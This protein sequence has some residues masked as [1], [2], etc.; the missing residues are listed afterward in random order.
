MSAD[1]VPKLGSKGDG[2]WFETT[3]WSVVLAAGSQNSPDAAKALA[4]LC[5][6]YWY[7]LYA[8]ARREGNGHEDAKDLTQGFFDKLL[9]N[10]TA[11]TADPGRGRFRNFLLTSFKNYATDEW[12]KGQRQKRGGGCEVI[13]IDGQTAEEWYRLEPVDSATPEILFDRK[14]A[15]ALLSQTMARLESE[16][17]SRPAAFAAL[18]DFLLGQAEGTSYALV[19][20]RLGTSEGA[21]KMMAM[22][23]RRRFQELL[24][25]GVAHTL[26]D[27]NSV[28]D[29]LRALFE[30][31]SS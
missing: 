15:M 21:V 29:E 4:T 9:Q 30:I 22:R 7:P 3:H 1:E 24:R 11:S 6:C 10:N 20:K 13:S 27:P 14:W 31:L 16:W 5:Q 18:K 17:V 28:D 23:L 8:F 19:A 12:T 25:E 2:Q 26:S